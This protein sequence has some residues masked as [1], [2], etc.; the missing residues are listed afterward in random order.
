M[1]DS[2]IILHE[3]KLTWKKFFTDWNNKESDHSS[4]VDDDIKASV[5]IPGRREDCKIYSSVDNVRQTKEGRDI[6]LLQ[7]RH[8]VTSCFCC[9]H[10]SK[11]TFNK[12]EHKVKTK[13]YKKKHVHSEWIIKKWKC[14]Y[15]F[16]AQREKRHTPPH[17]TSN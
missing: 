10:T 4:I 8:S 6:R 3:K 13:R 1:P 15:A 7:K 5:F 14:W 12:C 16:R 17:Q 2:A 11:R 9:D